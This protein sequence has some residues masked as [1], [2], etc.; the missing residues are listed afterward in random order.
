LAAHH[1]T[2]L[3]VNGSRN[4]LGNFLYR[5]SAGVLYRRGTLSGRLPCGSSTWSYRRCRVSPAGPNTLDRS[6]LQAPGGVSEREPKVYPALGQRLMIPGSPIRSCCGPYSGCV[7]APLRTLVH[8]QL[9][10][11]S[12]STMS[13][14]GALESLEPSVRGSRIYFPFSSR[15]LGLYPAGVT[16]GCAQ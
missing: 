13:C 7:V 6:T 14:R 15:T 8:Q 4:G 9:L 2:L 5:P 3:P 1:R 11:L 12:V 10:R 16:Q